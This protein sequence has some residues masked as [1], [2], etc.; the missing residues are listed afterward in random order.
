VRN[1]ATPGLPDIPVQFL[2]IAADRVIG[3]AEKRELVQRV[4]HSQTFAS[5]QA[6]RAFLLYVTDHA[7]S[8]ANERIKEQ[9]IGSED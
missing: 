5:S 1:A 4:V 8:S 3:A 7:A 6:L 2:A 9:W